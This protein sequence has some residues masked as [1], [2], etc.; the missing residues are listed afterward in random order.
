ML[1]IPF[2][3]LAVGGLTM[4][5]GFVFEVRKALRE[6]GRV[7]GTAGEGKRQSQ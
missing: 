2:G 6:L 4:M 7:F 1:I 3:M 5:G